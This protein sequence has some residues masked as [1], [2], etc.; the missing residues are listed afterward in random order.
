[1]AT[2]TCLQFLQF[3][4]QAVEDSSIRDSGTAES[5]QGVAAGDGM[6]S[7]RFFFA[8]TKMGSKMQKHGSSR[9][10]ESC[11]MGQSRV[12]IFKVTITSLLDVIPLISGC[13]C[14]RLRSAGLRSLTAGLWR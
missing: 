9:L 12:D 11:A 10:Y 6:L 1:M 5:M 4:W 7:I 2:Y 13:S 8:E 3:D 14:Y